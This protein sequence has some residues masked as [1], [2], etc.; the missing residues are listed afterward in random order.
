MEP[1]LYVSGCV[2]CTLLALTRLSLTQAQ[3][4]GTIITSL[5]NR[6]LESCKNMSPLTLGASKWQNPCLN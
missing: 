1:L 5:E 4:V 2:L 3:Q 6:E